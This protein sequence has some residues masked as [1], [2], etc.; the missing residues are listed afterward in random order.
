M[1]KLIGIFV[2]MLLIPVAGFSQ[3]VSLLN[4]YKIPTYSFH[5][6]KLGSQDFL[7]YSRTNLLGRRQI[8]KEFN[9]NLNIDEFSMKQSPKKTSIS[10]GTM[11]LNYGSTSFRY[12]G[13]DYNAVTGR[14][15]EKEISNTDDYFTGVLVAIN[16]TDKYFSNERGFFIHGGLGAIDIFN[17]R[18]IDPFSG[19][20]VNNKVLTTLNN[21]PL[22]VG[23]GRVIGVK[24]VVQAYIISDELNISM[25]DEKL[26]ELAEIIEKHSN[27][28]YEAEYRDDSEIKFHNDIAEIAGQHCESTKIDQIMN[29]SI[30]KT[31]SRY[32]GW[33]VRFGINNIYGNVINFTAETTDED[34][35]SDLYLQFK[36]TRPL[37]FNKQFIGSVLYSKNLQDD[38]G[39]TPRLGITSSFTI[40]HNYK[41]SSSISANYTKVYFEEKFLGNPSNTAITLKT[42]YLILNKFSVY[43]MF[44]YNKNNYESLSSL[45]E[46]IDPNLSNA[47]SWFPYAYPLLNDKT[48][49]FNFHVG[50]NFFLL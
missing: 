2:S 6:I 32:V 9:L 46:T 33:D 47:A 48:E 4:S 40:D 12:I 42:D 29:S 43:A 36:Y 39:R 10:V 11:S 25:S 21:F 3:N 45:V 22:G 30:Y 37:D 27:G 44:A 28:F 14:V 20:S 1:K 31:S 41:W 17:N 5:S 49:Y 24:N 15:E 38:D 8:E 26:L 19:R 7:D 34:Y 16:S 23:F 50:I 13:Y 18:I 35:I